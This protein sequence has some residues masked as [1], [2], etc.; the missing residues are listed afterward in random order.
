MNTFLPYASFRV[1]AHVLDR[2]RL[3]KQR[4]ECKQILRALLG[5]A[6]GWANHPA[7]KMWLGHERTLC[8][9]AIYI[10]DEWIARGY[11]DSQLEWFEI[12]YESLPRTGVPLWLGDPAFHA[13][14][15]SNLLR[16]DPVWY[17][18]FGWKEPTTLEYVW[19]STPKSHG[20]EGDQK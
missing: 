20:S 15:R 16:K 1:S 8:D 7:V 11:K 12:K 4:I 3:G 18:H 19:P 10:C 14:H 6:K 2:A 5:E 9:Y 17:G 13:S